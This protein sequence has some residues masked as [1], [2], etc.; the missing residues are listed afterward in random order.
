MK[1]DLRMGG[2]LERAL[3]FEKYFS[4]FT[5]ETLYFFKI[6]PTSIFGT[7]RLVYGRSR[8]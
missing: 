3:L 1:I 8:Q 4:L 5:P 6:W 7:A 2:N